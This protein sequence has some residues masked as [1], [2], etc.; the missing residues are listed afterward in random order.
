MAAKYANAPVPATY[1]EF[2]DRSHFT[3]GEPGWEQV[4]DLALTWA[5]A[6]ARTAKPVHA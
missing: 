4:A 5:T 6:N 3:A 2:P 1:R